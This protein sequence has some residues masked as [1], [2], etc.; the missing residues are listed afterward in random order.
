[1]Q[2]LG[3]EFST[4]QNDV[5]SGGQ[6]NLFPLLVITAPGAVHGSHVPPNLI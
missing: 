3:Q 5:K 4:P 1:M 2:A 6:V